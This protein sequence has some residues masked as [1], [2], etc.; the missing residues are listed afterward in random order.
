[1]D[2]MKTLY[3]E[4]KRLVGTIEVPG[5]KSIS[6]RSIML[7]SLAKGETIVHNFLE[8]E[9]SLRT[10]NAF[11][12]LGVKIQKN[13]TNVKVNGHGINGLKQP[14]APLNMGNSGTTVRL[15][16][17][18]LSALPMKTNL[19]GDDSLSKRPMGRVIE[20]LHKMGANIVSQQ[21]TLPMIIHGGGL[22]PIQYTLPVDSAQVKSAVLLAGLLT[23]GKTTVIEPN[24]TRDH[25]ERMLPLFGGT[26]YR[27]DQSITINGQQT[28]HGATVHVPGDISSAAFWIAGAVIVPNSDL[29]IEN[30]GLNPTRTGLIQVLKRMGA[31]INSTIRRYEGDEPVGDLQIRYS[32]NLKATEL[33]ADEVA[34]LVDE[35]PL[36]A[37]IA[38][39]VNGSMEINHIEELKYKESNRIKSTVET[40]KKLGAQIEETPQGMVI[41]GGNELFGS[42]IDTYGDHR[43]AMMASIASLITSSPVRLNNPDCIS[44]SYP[45]FFDELNQILK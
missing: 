9:D 30:V 40:L 45:G 39:Q 44:I 21:N 1:M 25:T 38:T 15:I 33:K 7:G 2:N 4:G 28:L 27:D 10:I 34:T 36:L 12:K 19:I 32:P 41:N 22:Q 31:M 23:N 13:G 43:I 18:I 35:V 42:E 8:S 24:I 37:L 5:D 3:N 20:P 16:C 11:E 14:D 29:I 26:V 17:G 6:H